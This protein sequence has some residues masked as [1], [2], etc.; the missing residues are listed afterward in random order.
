M[1]KKPKSSI[2]GSP[3]LF[4]GGSPGVGKT[5]V[6]ELLHKKLGGTLLHV[7]DIVLNHDLVDLEDEERD[8]WI[9]DPKKLNQ[10]LTEWWNPISKWTILETHYVELLTSIPVS[11]IC[12]LR[13]APKELERRLL[14]RG[15]T[16]AKIAENIQA[17]ILGTCTGSAREMFSSIPVIDIDTT[18]RT[19]Q[20][21]ADQILSL[22]E[23]PRKMTTTPGIDW[24]TSLHPDQLHAFFNP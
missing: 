16:N 22:L 14:K 3:V 18:H 21:I 19:P 8:T 20:D 23:H 1:S 10:W 11:M 24:L 2:L 4:V 17:E 12:I 6:S 15:W 7:N 9:V 5:E 13:C